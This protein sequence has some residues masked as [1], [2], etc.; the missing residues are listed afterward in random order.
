[1][2]RRYYNVCGLL[3]MLIAVSIAQSARGAESGDPCDDPNPF[4]GPLCRYRHHHAAP[5]HW[6]HYAGDTATVNTEQLNVRDEPSVRNS[7]VITILDL[8]ASVRII[9]RVDDTWVEIKFCDDAE[10]TCRGY[11]NSRFLDMAQ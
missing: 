5:V 2:N 8:G 6:H 1:M 7:N 11:V 9:R 4:G 3:L 10:I